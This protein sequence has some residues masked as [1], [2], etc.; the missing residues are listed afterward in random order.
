MSFIQF[1]GATHTV[2]GSKHLVQVD[3]YRTLVDCGLFQGLKQLRM[4]NWDPFPI[5]PASINSVILTH[6]HIDHT[7]YL[8]RL[9]WEGFSGPVYA[10]PA[11]VELARIMLPDS[12]RLQEEEAAYANKVGSTR[13]SPALPL[14]TEKDAESALKLFDSVNYHKSVRLTPKLSF[15]FVT[16]GHILGSCF[17]RMRIKDDDG[18]EKTIL[19]TG[20]IGRYNEPIV[21]DPAP[22]EEA[23][24]IVLESTYGD[25]RH[26]DFD[27]KAKLA[28]IINETSR[29]GGHIL[30]P[31]FAVGRTQHLLYLIRELEESGE[32]PIMPVVVDSPMAVSATK[33]YLRHREEHDLEMKDLVDEQRN[34]MATRRFTL[35]RTVQESKSITASE[36]PTIVISASGMATGGRILHHLMRRLPDERNTVVFVGFQAEGTRGRRLIDGEDEVR[37]FGQMVPVRARIERLENLS[38][39]ADYEEI[40]RWLSGFKRPPRKVFLVHGESGAM[41]ALKQKI[42]EKFGWSVQIP[43]YL[44]KFNL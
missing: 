42:T 12:A 36:E 16:A 33:L 7:G 20:D 25:R 40:L 32:I 6:A 31:A 4:R 2:T 9:V 29:R 17:V 43:D 18:E 11:T 27:V 3:G 19:L 38:A 23:D 41:N 37:I 30:I 34:P 39:H 13:H 24:Y 10:T 22:V 21:R 5:N 44:E 15:E 35:A 8:P 28:E 26:P 1:L 14:Y